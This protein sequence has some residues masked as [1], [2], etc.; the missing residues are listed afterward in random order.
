MK[1]ACTMYE[2]VKSDRNKKAAG[3]GKNLPCTDIELKLAKKT[4]PS[5]TINNLISC[6]FKNVALKDMNYEKLKAINSD[7]L[8]NIHEYVN[9][10]H[11]PTVIPQ[12]KFSAAISLKCRHIRSEE[13]HRN[14]VS[15]VSK[16]K[17][18]SKKNQT[19]SSNNHEDRNQKRSKAT[20][21]I[22]I[23]DMDQDKENSD[24]II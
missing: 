22:L 18:K 9:H 11:A 21:E 24:D 2:Q 4:N 17:Q 13:K 20:N 23:E 8:E 1:S 5:A 16:H 19:Y 6:C 7:V 12:T 15:T 14:G 3:I 10:I